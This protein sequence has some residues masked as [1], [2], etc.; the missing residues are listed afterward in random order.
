MPHV[1]RN[2]KYL[3]VTVLIIAGAAGVHNHMTEESRYTSFGMCDQSVACNGVTAG[4][5]CIGIEEPRVDCV[6]PRDA[7]DWRRA[8]AEC[9]LDA[10]GICNANP[11]M[12]G[13]AWAEDPRAEWQGKRCTQWA[14]E[15]EQVDL[16]SC[17]QTFTDIT[18]WS[19][20]EQSSDQ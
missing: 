12:T 15:Y 10:Q 8:E 9:G 20:Q 19:K 16:L 1:D 6:L 2:I 4:G 13:M 17:D 3:L 11:S 7:A 5:M 14:N 18:K